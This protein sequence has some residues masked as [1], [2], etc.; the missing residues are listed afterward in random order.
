MIKTFD[1]SWDE[2]LAA[3]ER[4]T[5]KTE[6]KSYARCIARE[7]NREWFKRKTKQGAF[8]AGFVSV[9]WRDCEDG[10]SLPLDKFLSDH[11]AGVEKLIC[12]LDRDQEAEAREEA[13]ER[14]YRNKRLTWARAKVRREHGVKVLKTFD[15]IIKHN[16]NRKEIVWEMAME[17]FKKQL[18]KCLK[19]SK[20]SKTLK[21]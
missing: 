14:A 18:A 21:A 10:E 6:I 4:K 17:E 15:R 13:A 3:G 2:A 19:T 7:R 9:H 20:P 8:E 5:V 11:G 16:G 1:K 12:D